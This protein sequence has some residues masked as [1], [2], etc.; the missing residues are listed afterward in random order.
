M[1]KREDWLEKWPEHGGINTRDLLLAKESTKSTL[2]CPYNGVIIRQDFAQVDHV[3]PLGYVAKKWENPNK[4]FAKDSE[5]LLLVSGHSNESKGEQGIL[6]W[7]PNNGAFHKDYAT[8]WHYICEKWKIKLSNA[9][10]SVIRTLM[11][12]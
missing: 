2:L 1:Y 4:E 3:V 9:E 5:N 6:E 11:N 12:G 7:L 8:I 10:K